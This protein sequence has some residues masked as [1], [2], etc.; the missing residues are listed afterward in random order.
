MSDNLFY[1]LSIAILYMLTGVI[2]WEF[3]F[4]ILRTYKKDLRAESQLLSICEDDNVVTLVIIL[5]IFWL[6]I[7]IYS[8]F[9]TIYYVFVASHK[10][11]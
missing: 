9:S 4:Q 5:T 8:I 3:V 10:E 2:F 1:T 7:L 11:R 6:P